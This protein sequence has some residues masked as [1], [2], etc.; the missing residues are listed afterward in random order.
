MH[1]L[2]SETNDVVKEVYMIFRVFNLGI[3]DIGLRIY[4]NPRELK[5]VEES[6]SATPYQK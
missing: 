5:F 4:S 1:R 2:A 6:F 3:Q